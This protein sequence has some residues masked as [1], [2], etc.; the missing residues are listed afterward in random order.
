MNTNARNAIKHLTNSAIFAALIFLAT[1]YL[2]IPLPVMGYVHLGDGFLLLA[3][4]L[5]PT[6]Y[7]IGAAIIGAGVADL[8]A[9]YALYLPATVL[10][11]ALTVICVSNKTKNIVCVRNAL[12]IIPA[13]VLCAGGYYIFEAII[14]K[15]L[16]SPIVSIPFNLAQAACGGVVFVLLG[17]LIDKNRALSKI[18]KKNLQ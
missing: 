15:S 18:F 3:A 1:S 6:P 5:L 8:M 2:S 17:L 9:G 12:G 4:A 16:V 11:K 14:A 13:A 7:A 10:I